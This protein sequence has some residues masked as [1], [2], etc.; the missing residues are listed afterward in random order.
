MIVCFNLCILCYLVFRS[1]F[2][3]CLLL[4]VCVCCLLPF[5]WRNKDNHYWTMFTTSFQAFRQC[6]FFI[7]TFI[8]ACMIFSFFVVFCTFVCFVFAAAMAKNNSL[9]IRLRNNSNYCLTRPLHHRY[10]PLHLHQTWVNY[11]LNNYN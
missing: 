6:F 4:S 5:D 7:F 2:V 10:Q 3:F 9:N 1:E 11:I 8:V